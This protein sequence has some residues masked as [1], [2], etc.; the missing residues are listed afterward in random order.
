MASRFIDTE[1]WSEDWFCEMKT[2]HQLFWNYITCKCDNAGIWK[3]N[4]IDFEVKSG[5][6]ISLDSFLQKVN[7][8]GGRERILVIEGG[9]WFLTGFIAFQWFNKQEFFDLAPERQK[10]H[11]HLYNLLLKSKIPLSKV[12]GLREVLETSRDKVKDKGMDENKKKESQKKLEIGEDKGLK[13]LIMPKYAGEIPVV[14]YDLRLFF[15]KTNQLEAIERAGWIKF[16]EFMKFNPSATFDDS[17][18]L[19]NTFRKFNTQKNGTGN[20]KD[21]HTRSLLTGIAERHLGGNG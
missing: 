2:E 9:R 3:P 20:K 5:T 11:L 7:E 12:R 15:E 18:H 21:D 17:K 10:L 13:I 14:I 16:D 6:K 1:I 19:Y 8:N 4:K